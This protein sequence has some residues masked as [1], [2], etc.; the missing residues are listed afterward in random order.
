MPSAEASLYQILTQGSPNPVSAIVGKRV[1]P[2]RLPQN[3][4]YPAIRYARISTPRS[5]WRVLDFNDDEGYASPRFQLNCYAIQ[6]SDALALGQ[7]VFRHL[8]S[9]HGT[10]SGLRIDVIA[11]EDEA[12]E[13]QPGV[14]EGDVGVHDQRLDVFIHH[15]E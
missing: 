14:A 8:K 15:A 4:V 7:A 11:P 6:H 13:Y 9:F 2:N 1:Y 10:V 5:E 3:V 12:G